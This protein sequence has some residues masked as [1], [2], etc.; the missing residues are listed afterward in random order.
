MKILICSLL[1][2]AVVAAATPVSVSFVNPGVPGVVDTDSNYYVGPYT[3]SINGKNVAAMC[4]DDFYETS[5]SWSANMTAANSSNLSATY[6]GNISYNVD[7][8]QFSSSQ[9]YQAEAY[10]DSEL[11]KSG[12]DRIHIQDAAWTIMDYVTGHTPHSNND[13]AVNA[14]LADAAASAHSFNDS[15]YSIISQV[16]PGTNA[17]QEF[18]VATAVPEPASWSLLAGALAVIGSFCRRSLRKTSAGASNQ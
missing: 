10:L 9:I 1:C 11:L 17:E 3:L 16:D 7:G 2:S 18:M 15:S 14:I 12:A 5:G 8:F 6:L 4:M 13:P